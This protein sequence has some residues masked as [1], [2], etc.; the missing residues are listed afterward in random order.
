MRGLGESQV[1]PSQLRLD[2]MPSA[3]TALVAKKRSCS[4]GDLSFFVQ[5]SP[6]A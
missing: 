4:F 2:P 1:L 3:V 5:H 6:R